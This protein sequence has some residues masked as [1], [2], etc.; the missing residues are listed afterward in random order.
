MM[1]ETARR[2][3]GIECNVKVFKRLVEYW[4]SILKASER[5]H[6]QH[7]VSFSI[8]IPFVTPF[9]SKVL[10]TVL[11]VFS[12]SLALADPTCYTPDK[13]IPSSPYQP[14]NTTANVLASY[15]E[16]AGPI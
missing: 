10:A 9:W 8:N 4:L 16:A 15:T 5:T 12:S 11:L 14:C 2:L 6:S 7:L 1:P 3:W 13:S